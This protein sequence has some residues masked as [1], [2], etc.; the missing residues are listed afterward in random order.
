MST[1]T[2][3][4]V[5]AVQVGDIF[6]SSWGYDQTNVDFYEV[7]GLTPASVR[8]RPVGLKVVAGDDFDEQVV[9]DT[10]RAGGVMTKRLKDWGGT[11][12]FRVDSF[13]SASPWDGKPQRRSG[14]FGGH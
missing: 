8:V 13:S 6:C 10:S 5:T 11:P 1:E 7:V 3:A 14:R 12:W 4:T 2:T 9:P